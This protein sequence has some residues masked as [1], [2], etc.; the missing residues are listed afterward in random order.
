VRTL[1]TKTNPLTREILAHLLTEKSKLWKGKV[2]II[3]DR[4]KGCGFCIEFCPK[5]VLEFS[6]ELNKKGFHPPRVKDENKCVLCGFCTAICPDFAI[7]TTKR[8]CEGCV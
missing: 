6:K 7:Y 3:K 1:N 8:P 2:C 5:E 4:C